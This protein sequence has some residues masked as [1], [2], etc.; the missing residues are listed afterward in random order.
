M[1]EFTSGSLFLKIHRDRVIMEAPKGALLKDFSNSWTVLLTE[2]NY[3]EELRAPE[4]I[5]SISKEVPLLYFYNYEDHFW[6]YR[7]FHM[8]EEVGDI[9]VSREFKEEVVSNF[10]RKRY[11]EKRYF[12]LVVSGKLDELRKELKKD[13]VFEDVF[14]RIFS[15]SNVEQFKLFGFTEETI[16]KL[17]QLLDIEKANTITKTFKLVDKFKKIINIEEMTNI[18]HER[19]L[20]FQKYDVIIN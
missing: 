16:Q 15:R 6:G 18:R 9:H 19:I 4:Y 17:S 7:I 8:G 2:D 3:A 10:A 1:S 5:Y 12:E 14:S 13:G 20:E 11:P